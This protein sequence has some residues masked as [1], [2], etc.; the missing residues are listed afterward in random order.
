ML[1][2]YT[3]E[4]MY[5]NLR[6]YQNS[7]RPFP[8]PMSS[9]CWTSCNAVPAM[10]AHM[11]CFGIMAIQTGEGTALKKDGAAITWA[12]YIGKRNDL[13]YGRFHHIHDDPER[14]LCYVLPV[15]TRSHYSNLLL[16]GPI[17]Q[18]HFSLP[19]IRSRVLHHYPHYSR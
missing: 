5:H 2:A 13:I 7:T 19:D 6:I 18:F 3:Y 15:Q 4:Y 8:L 16:G 9:V 14:L 17:F 11:D 10:H 12:I 1:N